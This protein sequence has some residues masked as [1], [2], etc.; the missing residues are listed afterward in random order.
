MNASI[1]Q[2]TALQHHAAAR[3][4]GFVDKFKLLLRREF[5]E[6]RGGFFWAPIITGIIACV[7]TLIGIIGGSALLYR[8]KS[9]GNIRWDDSGIITEAGTE[10]TRQAIGGTG[11]VFFLMGVGLAL[12]VLVFVVFFYSLGALYDERRD[13]SVLFWKSLPVSDSQTVLSKVTWALVLAPALS[14]GIGLLIGI[15]ILLLMTVAFYLNGIPDAGSL[16]FDSHPLKVLLGVLSMLPVYLFWALP[17]IGWLMLCSAWANRLPF[18]WAVLVPI[19]GCAMISMMAGI[20]GAISGAE[21]P[22]SEMWYVVVFRGLLSIVPMTWYA[23]DHVNAQHN[24]IEINGPEDF[25]RVVDLTSSWSAFATMELWIGAAVGIA[26]IFAAI[27][28]R[29][30]RDE[31]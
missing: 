9:E 22:H 21:F 26:M 15:V 12:A 11:D 19:L 14:I 17:T 3:S 29:R 30:W 23:N 31:G 4:F 1:Q 6:N 5:W 7:F 24:A 10:A 25:V 28:L 20:A 2:P 27:R 8:A 18:L 13:R 16:L